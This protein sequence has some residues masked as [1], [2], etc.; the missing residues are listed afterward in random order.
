MPDS[1][2][3]SPQHLLALPDPADRA[4]QRPACVL[5]ADVVGST[6]LAHQ[7]PL[8]QYA[9]LMTDLVQ[10][11]LLHFEVNHGQVLQHQ[12]DAVVC[13][14]AA[15]DAEHALVA[16]LQAHQRAARLELAAAVGARL[17]LRVG[18]AFGDVLIKRLLGTESAYGLPTNL[19]Q[20]LSRAAQ[21]GETLICPQLL[22]H[23]PVTSDLSVLAE[24]CPVGPL[25]GFEMLETVY[26]VQSPQPTQVKLRMKT[27]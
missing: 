18:L 20:R 17:K 11:L 3:P 16:A 22:A 5:F 24:A 26:R 7:L 1:Q 12:G 13:L 21:P 27:G 6:R 15:R 10:V 8:S 19:A 9:A 4:G 14:W 2:R 23:L 25:P